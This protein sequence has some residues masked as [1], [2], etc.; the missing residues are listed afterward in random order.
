MAVT[1]E[2]EAMWLLEHTT[3]LI[4]HSKAGG[5][6]KKPEMRKYP[7]GYEEAEKSANFSLTQAEAFKKRQREKAL[8]ARK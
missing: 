4:A 8:R 1:A 2:V 3:M 5:K 6:G 7:V